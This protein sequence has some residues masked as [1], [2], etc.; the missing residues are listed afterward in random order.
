MSEFEHN[1]NLHRAWVLWRVFGAENFVGG[2]TV[3]L[4]HVYPGMPRLKF[5]GFAVVESLTFISVPTLIRKEDMYL[6]TSWVMDDNTPPRQQF[7]VCI[8]NGAPGSKSTMTGF[9]SQECGML[10]LKREQSPCSV[11][12]APRM[13]HMTSFRPQV[14]LNFHPGLSMC[15]YSWLLCILTSTYITTN[16]NFV[17]ILRLL[18]W[19]WGEHA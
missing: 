19:G 7:C 3:V 5:E 17:N 1:S 14:Q 8:L 4:L 15:L 2:R 12:S 13:S 6:V 11:A 10:P 9:F 16:N 18:G